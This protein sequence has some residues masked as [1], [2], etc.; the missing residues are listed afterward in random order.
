MEDCEDDFEVQEE[1]EHEQPSP[2]DVDT[3]KAKWGYSG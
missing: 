3:N 2:E 1:E